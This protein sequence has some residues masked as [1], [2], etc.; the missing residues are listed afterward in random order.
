MYKDKD[1]NAP[2][3][4]QLK[5]LHSPD[6]AVVKMAEQQLR[7]RFVGLDKEN[8]IL[9]LKHHLQSGKSCR[10]WAYIRLLS[11]WDEAFVPIIT[12]LWKTYHEEK[13]SWVITK[14]FLWIS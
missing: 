1:W 9:V 2:L 3:A 5:D 4:Q 10:D 11:Y 13:C 12:K 6:K 7:Q 8:Q 14:I